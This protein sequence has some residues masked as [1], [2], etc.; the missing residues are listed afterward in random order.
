M[1]VTG[2]VAYQKI[3]IDGP[4]TSKVIHLFGDIHRYE[5][6]CKVQST[7]IVDLI[8]H[9]LVDT[10][11]PID[12]FVEI[13]HG[14]Y[15]REHIENELKSDS[16]SEHMYLESQGYLN[17]TIN[18]FLTEYNCFMRPVSEYCQK[19][20]PHRFHNVDFRFFPYEQIKYAWT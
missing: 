12:L 9:T 11:E 16:G 10:N 15:Q 13:P 6:E 14:R 18:F 3:V 1:N 20:F 5:S 4:I 19:S 2:P 17:E 8:H 7:S